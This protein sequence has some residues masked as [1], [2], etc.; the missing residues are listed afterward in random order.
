MRLI[1]WSEKYSMN[2]KEI[3]DQH[4]KLV[5]MINELHDTMKQAKSK[6][7]SL[8]VINELVAYTQ[9]HFS[10]EEKYMKQFGYSDH[11][12]HKKEH[13]KFVYK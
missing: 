7:T 5:E 11:V 6:E 2:I 4:K 1:T 3:D 13:E 9:Y 12:S 10:T 8:I